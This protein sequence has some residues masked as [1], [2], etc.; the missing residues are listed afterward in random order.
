[1]RRHKIFCT[2]EVIVCAGAIGTPLILQRS[3]IGPDDLLSKNQIKTILSNK[4]VGSNLQDHYQ[5]RLVYKTSK[6]NSM[7]GIYNSNYRKV[8]SGLKYF[9][10]KKGDLTI[11]AGVAGMFFSSENNKEY[12]D[13]QL[14]LIPFSAESPGKLHKTPGMTC[15]ITQLRPDSRGKVSIRSRDPYMKPQIVFNYLN[16]ERDLTSIM[17]GLRFLADKF[18]LKNS[19]STVDEL[20]IPNRDV[21]NDNDKLA[22]YIKKF[23]TTI[24][25]PTSTCMMTSFDSDY[26]V[27]DPDLKVKRLENIRVADASVIPN[28]ISGNTNAA[29]MMIG[30][31]AADL[32]LS[33]LKA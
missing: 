27:V 5:A 7:N 4:D 15:S 1:M 2:K 28:I 11:G 14:H 3:G 13:L 30:E 22:E 16:S 23:G 24:F 31:T 21:I 17:Y 6:N 18:F 9:L 19:T 33:D 10:T 32:I 29:C 20:M 26:G 8:M 25:H 12:P